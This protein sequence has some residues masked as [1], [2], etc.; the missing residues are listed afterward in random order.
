MIVGENYGI[1][2][3]SNHKV[4]NY[5]QEP[6][7]RARLSQPTIFKFLSVVILIISSA[8]NI[9]PKIKL[10]K[11]NK[12]CLFQNSCSQ[13]QV[14]RMI[15]LQVLFQKQNND[16]TKVLTFNCWS[17]VVMSAL[18]ISKLISVHIHDKEVSSTI[19]SRLYCSFDWIYCLWLVLLSTGLISLLAKFTVFII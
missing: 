19:I 18:A 17:H 3:R 10:N 6:H 7:N 11:L 15:C 8:Y 4:H 16:T 1:I 13:E 5:N 2:D 12:L 14:V 9:T